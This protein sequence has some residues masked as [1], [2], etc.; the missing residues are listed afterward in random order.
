[1][2]LIS[3]KLIQDKYNLIALMTVDSVEVDE[4]FNDIILSNKNDVIAVV[5]GTLEK[6]DDAHYIIH[7]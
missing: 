2:K 5:S 1:M 4:K 6:E 7:I 3:V